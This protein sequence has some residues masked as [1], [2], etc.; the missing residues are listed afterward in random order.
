[1]SHLGRWLSALVD[2][3]LDGS[4]RDHVLNHLAGCRSCRQEA[5]A[6][7]ALKRRLIALGETS[8]EP[9][10]AS[11]LIELARGDRTAVGAVPLPATGL[12]HLG[13]AGDLGHR[14]LT[15][16]WRL[17]AASASGSLVAIGVMAFLL[18]NGAT[19]PPVPEVTPSVDSYLIQHAYDAG[20]ARAGSLPAT[21]KAPASHG[22]VGPGQEPQWRSNH[23]P[24][25]GLARPIDQTSTGGN[26][27]AGAG[28]D[29]RTI[30][31][32][33]A[34]PNA[35]P[36]PSSPASPPARPHVT[37]RHRG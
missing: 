19:A 23:V 32:T 8:A 5:N 1:M 35:S 36:S 34:S 7:R 12:A 15:R 21:G 30:A 17:A 33:A 14:L 28:P 22:Q 3:E 29:R 24:S 11:R 27:A 10:I 31:S 37:S 20:Q 9:A 26:G 25:H 4:E 13:R 6:M 2:G 16:S 18:G